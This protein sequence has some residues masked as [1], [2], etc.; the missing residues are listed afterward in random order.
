MIFGRLTFF[1]MV[2]MTFLGVAGGVYVYKPIF[3]QY[4]KDQKLLKENEQATQAEK[5]KENLESKADCGCH[6]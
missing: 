4:T 5:P 3:E 1:Q 6:H 2:A